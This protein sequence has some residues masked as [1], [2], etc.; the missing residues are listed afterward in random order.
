[1]E[2]GPLVDVAPV[3]VILGYTVVQLLFFFFEDDVLEVVVVDEDDDTFCSK[4][5]SVKG[6]CPL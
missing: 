5:A 6:K 1:M 2:A 4:T 3:M